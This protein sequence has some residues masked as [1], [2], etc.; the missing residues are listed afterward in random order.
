MAILWRCAMRRSGDVKSKR[1]SRHKLVI[2]SKAGGN[3]DIVAA[4]LKNTPDYAVLFLPRFIVKIS[5]SYYLSAE[6]N[7]HWYHLTDKA[8]A[9]EKAAYRAH[10]NRVLRWFE[11]L[12]G[13][14]ALVQFNVLYWAE[15]ELAAACTEVG[16]SFVAVHK[17]CTCSPGEHKSR[18]FFYKKAASKFSG[19]AIAVYNSEFKKIIERAGVARRNKIHVPGCARIDMLHR[20]RESRLDVENDYVLFYLIDAGGSVGKILDDR[21]DR[22]IRGVRMPDGSLGDW[23]E[24]VGKVNKAVI[25]V[26]SENPDIRFVCKCKTGFEN[27]QFRRIKEA[28]DGL[29]LPAN[30]EVITSGVGH[31]LLFKASVVIGFNST[32]VFEAMAAGVPVI[33]PKLFSKKESELADYAHD[34]CEGALMPVLEKEF[35]SMILSSARNKK[36][37]YKL[38]RNQ[39]HA[40]EL[41][42]GNKD[43]QSGERL[44][45][46]LDKAIAKG[47]K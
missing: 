43:G 10:L 6:A 21:S 12:F 1:F 8:F 29:E 4:Y 37:Y 18:E 47:L 5:A 36:R 33:V 28:C 27:D 30:V 9:S 16:V 32:V 45:E 19:D 39:K 26:A 11:Y 2:L 25:E 35:K 13:L 41:N 14:S 24:M 15:R 38:T 3:D 42:V 31:H 17:E 7:D 20:F 22:W 34:L 40:L 44:R 23:S 46:L